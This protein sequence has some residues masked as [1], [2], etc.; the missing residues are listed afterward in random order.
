M[1]QD[2]PSFDFFSTFPIDMG[3]VKRNQAQEWVKLSE[4]RLDE[5]LQQ[6]ELLPDKKRMAWITVLDD[7]ICRYPDWTRDYISLFLT[8]CEQQTNETAKRCISKSSF[9][10]MKNKPDFFDKKQREKLIEI[11]F[12]WLIDGSLVA[13]KANCLSVLYLLRKENDW[14][15]DELV[16]AIDQQ[17]PESSLAF[18]SRAEKILQQIK[19]AL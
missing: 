4:I 16:A 6:L 18:K 11:H 9:Y 12:S 14:V 15:L 5:Y 19:R 7:Y 2:A 13:T 3:L 8:F 1:K 10:L 17:I